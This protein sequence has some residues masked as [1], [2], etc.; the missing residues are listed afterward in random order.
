MAFS[1]RFLYNFYNGDNWNCTIKIESLVLF[2]QHKK[3]YV[4]LCVLW[5]IKFFASVCQSYLYA[6]SDVSRFLSG[7]KV[8]LI[9]EAWTFVSWKALYLA[10]LSCCNNAT[11]SHTLDSSAIQFSEVPPPFFH[12]YK[13]CTPEYTRRICHTKNSTFHVF[14]TQ[15]AN[16]TRTYLFCSKNSLNLWVVDGSAIYSA[17]IWAPVQSA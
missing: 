17:L 11:H 6:P 2:I 1:W 5:G 13:L 3:C 4:C 10:A 7:A 9:A 12:M 15:S 8:T 14:V 16:S